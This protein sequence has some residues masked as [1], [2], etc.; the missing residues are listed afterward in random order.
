MESSLGQSHIKIKHKVK[1]LVKLAQARNLPPSSHVHHFPSATKHLGKI[2]LHMCFTLFVHSL[3]KY[4][5]QN[6]MSNSFSYSLLK[7]HKAMFGAGCS[8]EVAISL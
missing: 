6:K 1:S 8:Y 7:I 3:T 4:F 5:E 2:K